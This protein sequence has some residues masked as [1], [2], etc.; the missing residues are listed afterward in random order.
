[1][2]SECKFK[3]KVF[4]NKKILKKKKIKEKKSEELKYEASF[5]L[6]EFLKEI[7]AQFLS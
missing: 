7:D 6:R 2:S 5:T 3:F 4:Q 1:M